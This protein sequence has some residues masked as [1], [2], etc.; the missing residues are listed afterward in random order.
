[1]IINGEEGETPKSR[2][3]FGPRQCHAPAA[4]IN[5]KQKYLCEWISEH[6]G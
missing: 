1:M 2:L 5:P 4:P 3:R 6:T